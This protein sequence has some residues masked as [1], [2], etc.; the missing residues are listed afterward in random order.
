[1]SQQNDKSK[2]RQVRINAEFHKLLRVEAAQKDTTIRSLL[3]SKAG[4][5]TPTPISETN[6]K[7]GK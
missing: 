4:W 3:E 5:D 6:Q 7:R 2:T 1:M